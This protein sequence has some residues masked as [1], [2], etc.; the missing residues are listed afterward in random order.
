MGNKSAP[1]AGHFFLDMPSS[2]QLGIAEMQIQCATGDVLQLLSVPV[3]Q[4][5]NHVIDKVCRCKRHALWQ[6]FIRANP[7]GLKKAIGIDLVGHIA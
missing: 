2:V 6:K 5:N 7:F 4:W 1:M 3:G